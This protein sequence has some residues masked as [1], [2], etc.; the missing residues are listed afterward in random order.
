M[1]GE[2]FTRTVDGCTGVQYRQG[3]HPNTVAAAPSPETAS[4]QCWRV[5][6]ALRDGPL[7]REQLCEATG[8]AEKTMC[9]RLDGLRKAGHV[10]VAGETRNKGGHKVTLYGVGNG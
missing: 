3:Q 1:E 2:L 10:V 9:W 7:S 6:A 8:I 4:A 5:L